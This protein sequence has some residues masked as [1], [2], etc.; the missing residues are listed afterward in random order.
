MQ[1]RPFLVSRR[2][3]AVE[4]LAAAALLRY[5]IRHIK[6]WLSDRKFDGLE[7]AIMGT[8]ELR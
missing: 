3:L 6:K 8:Y 1:L 2:R 5:G 7:G 4:V